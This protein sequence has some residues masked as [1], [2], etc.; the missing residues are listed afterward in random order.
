MTNI[1]ATSVIETHLNSKPWVPSTTFGRATLAANSVVNKLFLAFLLSDPDVGVQFLKDTGLIRSSMVCCKCWSA[2][3]D[4]ETH[5]YAHQ[6]VN[7]T[8]DFLYVRTR[9]S[10]EHDREHVPACETI[11]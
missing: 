4:H 6:T 1:R 10:H 9:G 5:V 7:H 2:Y 11:P 3:R 8:I